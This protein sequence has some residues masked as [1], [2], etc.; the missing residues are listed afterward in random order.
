MVLP[1]N[2]KH[3]LMNGASVAA[4]D[5]LVIGGSGL[6]GQEVTRQARRAGAEVLATFY[7]HGSAI[8]GVE[9]RPLD[10]RNRDDVMA[11]VQQCR[12]AT[13][14]NAAFRQV[15]WVTTADGAMHVAAATAAAGSRLVH[16]SSDA[17]FSGLADSYD[18]TCPPDPIT[19]YGAAKAAAET[20]VKG[21]DPGAVIA[22]T[23]LIIG[24][25]NSQHEAY[26]HSLAS[27]IAT[28]VLFADDVRCPIHVADLASALL[29]LA[30]S[31]YPGIHHIAGADAL[32]RHELGILIARRDG[33]DEAKLLSGL[34]SQT[35]PPGPLEVRLNCAVTQSRLETRLR[36]AREFLATTLDHRGNG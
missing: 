6:L 21:L 11:L 4:M 33:L 12:P 35:G 25:G 19:P 15:D 32:N 3:T 22:R 24:H 36:G 20:A 14:I 30:R 18:E 26:V 2:V 31:P 5:L 17:V 13:I 28:G 27:G 23:S 16:V 10:I 9:G 1:F 8:A 7:R 29:E 34:R